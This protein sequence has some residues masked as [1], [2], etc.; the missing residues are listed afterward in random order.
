[1]NLLINSQTSAVQPL[2]FWEL[3]MNKSFHPTLYWACGYLSMLVS[4]LKFLVKKKGCCVTWSLW[5]SLPPL[6]KETPILPLVACRW[7]KALDVRWI[8]GLVLT[9]K[10]VSMSLKFLSLPFQPFMEPTVLWFKYNTS[11][12]PRISTASWNIRM[13]SHERLGLSNH[14]KLDSLFSKASS[15]W[16]QRSLELRIT[17]SYWGEPQLTGGLPVDSPCVK[18]I[19][20]SDVTRGTIVSQI[21]SLTIVYSTVYSGADQR[22]HQSSASLAFVWRIHRGQVASNPENVSILWRHHAMGDQ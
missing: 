13:M 12:A 6:A 2:K 9:S 17:G 19:H 3:G 11:R 8:Y 5:T 4:T 18:G 7:G 22:K 21:T 1:M 16:R 15:C 10:V 20:Y 14:R